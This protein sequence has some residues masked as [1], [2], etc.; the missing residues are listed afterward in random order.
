MP[1]ATKLLRKEGS[2]E[3][4]EISWVGKRQE[5]KKLCPIEDKSVLASSEPFG[6]KMRYREL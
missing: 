1:S 2:S 5:K 6:T 3:C 4:R